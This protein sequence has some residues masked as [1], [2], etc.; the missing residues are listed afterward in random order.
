MVWALVVVSL[1]VVDDTLRRLPWSG[2]LLYLCGLAA[3]CAVDYVVFSVSTLYYIGYILLPV[4]VVFAL[5]CL[6]LS[7]GHRCICGRCG[8]ELSEK[9]ICPQCGAMNI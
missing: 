2:A 4:Y 6:R 9:G 5:R 7:F 8:A 3:V 1:A